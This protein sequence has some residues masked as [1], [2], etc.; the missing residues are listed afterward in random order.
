MSESKGKK[1]TV[2]TRS[3]TEYIYIDISDTGCGIAKENL[4]K[5]FTPF[6]HPEKSS[7]GKKFD[8]TRI[9][10]I[11]LFNTYMF[12]DSYGVKFDVESELGIGTTFHI[13]IP[14]YSNI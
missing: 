3:D 4:S 11:S 13:K 5:V 6:F 12:L 7:M 8:K 1:L 9:Y 2:K 14:I 10:L